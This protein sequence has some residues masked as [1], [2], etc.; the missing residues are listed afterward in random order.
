VKMLSPAEIE[1]L[2]RSAAHY[3]ANAQRF[4]LGLKAMGPL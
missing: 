2:A 3:R 1:G 4:R